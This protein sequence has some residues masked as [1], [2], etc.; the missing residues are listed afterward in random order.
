MAL[1]A[2]YGPNLDPHR[3]AERAPASPAFGS[4]WL[5]GW[6]LTFAGAEIGWEGAMATVVEDIE[7]DVFV[8][9]YDM[10]HLDELALD[11]WE[12]V[13]LGYW[14]K[15]RVRVDTGEANELA[16]LYSLDAYEGGMPSQA[17]LD[18]IIVSAQE[19]GAPAHYLDE[20]RAHPTAE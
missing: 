2:A 18:M 19:A 6:R 20:L 11:A 5:R 3:M 13:A 10:T 14:R 17:Y 15:I 1:Y 12:G 7:S 4:G 16:W 8:M 9:L